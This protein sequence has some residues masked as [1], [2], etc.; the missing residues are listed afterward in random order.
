[1]PVHAPQFARRLGVVRPMSAKHEDAE[2]QRL[3]ALRTRELV[4][5]N[6]G[7]K[8]ELADLRRRTERRLQRHQVRLWESQDDGPGAAFSFSDLC[9]ASADRSEEPPPVPAS[10]ASESL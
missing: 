10:H 4:E 3:V 8:R 1:M 5:A 7:L 2:L 9:A 6:E